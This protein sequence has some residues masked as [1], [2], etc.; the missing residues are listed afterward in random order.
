[1]PRPA[2]NA[3]PVSADQLPRIGWAM[4]QVEHVET[5]TSTDPQ[6]DDTPRARCR[7]RIRARR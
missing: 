5:P 7:A 3:R 1:M 2:V 4:E 6:V